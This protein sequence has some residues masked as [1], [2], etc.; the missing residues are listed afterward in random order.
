MSFNDDYYKAKT[1]DTHK[2]E[3]ERLCEELEKSDLIEHALINDFG[4][5]SNFDIHIYPVLTTTH[6]TQRLKGLVSK[7]IKELSLNVKMNDVFP[8]IR[9]K[10]EF[11]IEYDRSFWAFDLDYNSFDRSTNTFSEGI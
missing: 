10:T 6:I 1:P 4:R 8:A 2:E 9:K 11:R 5:Y 7:A 3:M